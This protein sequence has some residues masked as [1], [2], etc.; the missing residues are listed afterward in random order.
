MTTLEAQIHRQRPTVYRGRKMLPGKYVYNPD[1]CQFGT[2]VDYCDKCNYKMIIDQDHL[3]RIM[4]NTKKA[5]KGLRVR[6]LRL[7]MNSLNVDD[8]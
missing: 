5:N 6:I 7:L 3:S 8:I 2:F 4:R 1:K